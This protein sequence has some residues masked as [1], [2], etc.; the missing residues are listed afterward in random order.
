M[1]GSFMASQDPPKLPL[2]IKLMGMTGSSNDTEALTAVRKR[3]TCFAAPA[4]PGRSFSSAKSPSSKTP[5]HEYP[6]QTP[7]HAT[8]TLH[9]PEQ[10]RLHLHNQHPL[11]GGQLLPA[12]QHHKD[13]QARHLPRH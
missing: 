8:N 10:P 7:L 2:L 3:A 13:R 6:N 9:H 1:G 5:L 4:G 12:K 11:M